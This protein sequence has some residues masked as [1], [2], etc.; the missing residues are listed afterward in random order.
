M[1]V[2]YAASEL[3]HQQYGLMGSSISEVSSLV[4]VLSLK[5]FWS[6]YKQVF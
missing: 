1:V 2:T 6:A 3:P 5:H 4:N